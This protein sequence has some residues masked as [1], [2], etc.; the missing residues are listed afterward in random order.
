MKL[1]FFDSGMGGL[2]MME[3]CRDAYPNHDYVYFGDTKNLPY[4]PK[5]VVD[6]LNHMTPCLLF[7]LEEERCDYVV[8]ACN[9]A[10]AQS[11]ELFLKQYPH[12]ESFIV[13]IVDVTQNYFKLN[14]SNL[15]VAH[16]LA[17]Q[18]TVSSSVYSELASTTH[19]IPMPGLVD[20]IEADKHE[21]AV[22]LVSDALSYYNEISLLLLGCTHYVYLKD[23]LQKNYP[24]TKI[25]G[26]DEILIDFFSH[27]LKPSLEVGTY[28]YYV[29]GDASSYSKRHHLNFQSIAFKNNV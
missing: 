11:L 12:Y 18:R 26:Q 10:G 20:L 16:V 17:T 19:Q 28:Y 4:G 7:L 29:T 27:T 5:N 13:N 15:H 24:N 2:Y 8:V 23:V 21:A 1:G 9:T 22:L 3:A 14:Y 6:I 25:I